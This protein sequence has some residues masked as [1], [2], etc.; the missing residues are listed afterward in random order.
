VE[1]VRPG[2][3]VLTL[4]RPE[5]R[6]AIDRH[7]FGQL[8]EAIEDLEAD[9][10]VRVAILTG[11][12]KG[13]CAGVDLADAS[14]EGL[15]R[16]RRNRR[17]SPALALL[18]GT[19]PVVGAVNGACYGGGLELALACDF[20]VAA[21]SATFADPH[22]S[23]GL[24]PSWGGG[25]LLPGAIGTRHAKRLA[26]TGAPVTAEQALIYGLVSELV[27]GEQ[28]LDRAVELAGQVAS[29]PRDKV[30][31]LR[32]MYDAGEGTSRAERLEAERRA[33]VEAAIDVTRTAAGGH[34]YGLRAP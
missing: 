8:I 25:A 20:L 33:L 5:K 31:R 9:P 28:L 34:R 3:R 6:N 4:N 13:F 11:T 14:D 22:L 7:L 17:I 32:R 23:L 15:L 24:L 30:R 10:S 21:E 27:P 26:L 2:V 1:D 12:G 29:A 18:E 16:E 19:T